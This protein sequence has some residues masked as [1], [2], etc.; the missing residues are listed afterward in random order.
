MGNFDMMLQEF[1]AAMG[2]SLAA[3]LLSQLPSI[4]LNLAI[5]VFTGL[6][7]YTIA[8]RRGIHHPWLAWV[9]VARVWLVGCISDHYR[10]VARGQTKN[11]RKVL[12]VLNI[13][14]TVVA[15]A[16]V[17]LCYVMLY[18][19]FLVGLDHLE[20]LDGIPTQEVLDAVMGPAVG[21]LLLALVILPVAIA[22]LIVYLM[23][24]H[25][26]YSSCDPNNAT[27]Y[28]VLGIFIQICQPIFLMIC[29]NKDLGMPIRA[30]Q[31]PVYYKPVAYTQPPQPIIPEEEPW[32]KDAE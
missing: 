11:R 17:V 6:G 32:E 9:P 19:I 3:Y 4:L 13:V 20:N 10:N 12:L 8:K 26:I 2:M 28:L 29:R 21:M 5:Y 22:Y 1:E 25:D 15:V 31:Q 30:P 7:L 23:A 18:N 16:V 27:L 14:A 24:M